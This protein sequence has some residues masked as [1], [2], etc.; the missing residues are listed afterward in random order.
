MKV[1]L[2]NLIGVFFSKATFNLSK[3]LK[4]FIDL[5][6]RFVN[7]KT[8]GLTSDRDPINVNKDY[9]FFNPKLGFT[10]KVDNKHSLYASFARANKEPNRNDFESN[11]SKVTHESLNDF[12]F[13]WR[14]ANKNIKLNTN[15]YYMQ[16]DNQLVLTGALD[17]S[18]EYLRENVKDSYRLGLEVDATFNVSE[19]FTL[20]SNIAFSQNKIKNLMHRT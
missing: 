19:K 9:N 1:I 18:G 20:T 16:Y 17:N 15:I 4:T 13:G 7:Y 2:K 8:N 11:A 10:Y 12:E 6:G 5:Q 3:N 14:L